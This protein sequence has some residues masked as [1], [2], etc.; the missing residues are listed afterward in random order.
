MSK[1]K[2]KLAVGQQE[3]TAEKA[4]SIV[5]LTIVK[6]LGDFLQNDVNLKVVLV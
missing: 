4:L 2:G 1:I 3:P 5:S 6:S